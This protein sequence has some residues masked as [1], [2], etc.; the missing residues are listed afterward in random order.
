MTTRSAN[1]NP[2]PSMQSLAVGT[3]R[4]TPGLTTQT[5]QGR[6][7]RPC[8]DCTC[9]P[10]LLS[11]QGRR[12]SL[13]LRR[14]ENTRRR[15][16][17][18]CSTAIGGGSGQESVY[19]SDSLCQSTREV[20]TTERL[21]AL[22]REM[23]KHELCCYIVP[24][25]DEHQSEYVS[26]ADQRRAF[27]SGFNGSAGI[28]CITRDLLNFNTE[29]PEGRSILSTDGRYFNQASQELDYN[30]TLLRQGEDTFTWQDWCVK[31]A[32]EMSRGLGGKTAK[33][34][35][36]PR[37]V[38]HE[39]VVAFNRLITQKAGE[40]A[41]VQLVPVEENLID[42]IW[43]KFERPPKKQ[44][45][46][47]IALSEDYSGENFKSK[48]SRLQKHLT[49]N[50]RNSGPLAI[51]ALDEI[52]W[53]LNLR[54]SDIAY[55]PVFFAYAIAD[56]D[57]VTLF[58]DNALHAEVQRYCADNEI[59]L[60]PYDQFW[61]RLSEK[62]QK[63]DQQ[64]KFLIPDNSSWQLVRHVHCNYKSV[65]SPIDIFKS[66]KNETEIRNARRAQV[67]DAVCLTQYFAWLEDQLINKGALID[68]YRA[69]QKLTE[70]RRTQKNYK[71]DSFETISST[72]ANAAVI[73]YAPPKDGSSMIN[74]DKVYLCDSGS[75]YLE[76]TTDIT[77]TVHYGNPSQE[78]KDRYTLVLKGHLALER[79]VFPEGTTGFQI[80]SIAR[81]PLWS[82]GLDYRHGTG[83]GIGSFLNVHEGPIGIGARPSLLQYPLQSGNIIS[84]EPGY[85]K[86]GEYGLR[87]ESDMLVTH[88]GLKFGEKRFLQFENLTLVPYCRKLINVKLLT[89]EERQQVNDYH[90][91]IW[92]SIVQFTQ[93]Q[94]IT[95]KW[96]KRETSEL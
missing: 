64:Q 71:G 2:K 68:E 9:S 12:S 83:H 96:L 40:G 49:K 91:R 55:N 94:S 25:E 53:L 22:R 44:L 10:G 46:S 3:S 67:K 95:F 93:P 31:E 24:S 60:E 81:Q 42:A 35:V 28:A 61:N 45:Q 47:V 14:L 38:S 1:L 87:I 19:S 62:S 43:P 72:G 78:E 56:S 20:N 48:R 7:F 6:Q 39:L 30:W 4:G 41:D 54:G 36:D 8:A 70:I 52:C 26:S 13:F 85:Y 89:K 15:S 74:P 50:Y 21:L 84:N 76:G 34:G 57:S 66:I 32:A 5:V 27:I 82:Q 23:V 33:I 16:S 11:R 77:R 37:L 69:A 75:Q 80:D 59:Q 88:S 63:L 58:T 86:D 51:V 79:L 65:H 92:S 18:D 90:A 29:Q 17:R 73:H